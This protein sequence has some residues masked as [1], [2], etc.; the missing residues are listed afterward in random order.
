M[1]V[2]IVQCL[3][4]QRHCLLAL[5]YESLTGEADLDKSDMLRA[6]VVELIARHVLNPWC[7]ICRSRALWYEDKATVFTSMHEAEAAFAQLEEAQR[8][9]AEFLRGSRN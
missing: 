6:K 5:A 3:C 2:R 4:Q 1:K 9:T 8:A 7:G